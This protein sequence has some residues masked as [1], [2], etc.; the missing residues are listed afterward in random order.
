M[1]IYYDNQVDA[2]YIELSTKKPDGVVEISDYI[3][4][5]TTKDEEIVGIELLDASKKIPIETLFNHEIDSELLEKFYE[6]NIHK[7]YPELV[8]DKKNK[9]K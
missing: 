1:K 8:Q 7:K 5:D 9:T 3:N 6:K 4:L 2:A